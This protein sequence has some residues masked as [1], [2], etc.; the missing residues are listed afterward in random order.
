M[1]EERR[2]REARGRQAETL[3]WLYLLLKGYR[4]L[5]R[6]Y[7]CPAG[8]IDLICRRGRVIVFIE[9]KARA[10]IDDAAA[11]ITPHQLGRIRRAGDYFL[12]AHPRLAGH[13][14]RVDALLVAPGRLP[15]HLRAIV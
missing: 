1:R 14:C 10:R 4:L 9:V 3:A 6:R 13:D 12:A 8:E 11:A 7:R 15:R 5:A 2:R